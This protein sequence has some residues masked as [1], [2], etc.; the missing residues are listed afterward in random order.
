M[1]KGSSSRIML[2]IV[3]ISNR[4]TNCSNFIGKLACY[5]SGRSM[6]ASV[7][8]V[9]QGETKH[10]V[11]MH[12]LI[13]NHSQIKLVHVKQNLGISKARNLGIKTLNSDDCEI[14]KLLFVDD[15]VDIPFATLDYA[16]DASDNVVTLF[17][18]NFLNSSRFI[19]VKEFMF[20]KLFKSYNIY[21]WAMGN[22]T[23]ILYPNSKL[24]FDENLGIQ[25]E[26]PLGFE[27]IDYLI[28][29]SKL[30]R[31]AHSNHVIYHPP[32]I[33]TSA[34]V[35]SKQKGYATS[36][37]YVIKKQKSL[38][39]YIFLILSILGTLTRCLVHFLKGNRQEL[40]FHLELLLYKCGKN[41]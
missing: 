23:A 38:S 27:D 40:R 13:K 22:G 8:I 3:L 11:F 12:K 34:D 32:I 6:R 4:V 24:F 15:D 35:Q 1:L 21:L 17:R 41:V 9:Y 39:G 18:L 7:V 29:H 5:F 28:T 25:P 20:R 19:Q 2:G 36:L 26:K 31:I 14:T 33:Y 10:A 30:Y 37:R 16:C